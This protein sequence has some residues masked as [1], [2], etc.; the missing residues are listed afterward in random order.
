MKSYLITRIKKSVGKLKKKFANIQ[1]VKCMRKT[2]IF[3]PSKLEINK[4]NLYR[5]CICVVDA[6]Y[7]L[8][9]ISYLL[10]WHSNDDKSFVRERKGES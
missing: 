7:N 9:L 4:K 1:H 6:H 3:Q 10:Y 8:I 2:F 5:N